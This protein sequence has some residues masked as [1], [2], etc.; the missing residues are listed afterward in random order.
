M[1][2]SSTLKTCASSTHAVDDVLI[3]YIYIYSIVQFFAILRKFAVQ[4]FCLR[5]RSRETIKYISILAV[6]LC[7][8]V[9]K[10]LYCKLIW[11]ELSL[12]HISF[13]FLAK[14]CS[15]LYICSENISR[16]NMRNIV[17]FCDHVSLCAFS[18]ARCSKHYYFHNF[19]FLHEQCFYSSVSA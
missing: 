17:F 9:E 7:D 19:P 14:F 3:R 4:N 2:C 18:G 16:G 6:S 10:K 5:Y 8:S 11:Y 15:V 13:C 1:I 12:I